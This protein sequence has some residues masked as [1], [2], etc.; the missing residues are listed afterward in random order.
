MVAYKPEWDKFDNNQMGHGT[1][2]AGIALY[3]DVKMLLESS[4]VHS[5]THT[6]E[7]SKI[8]PDEGENEPQLY[9]AITSKV[10]SEQI[11]NHPNRIRVNCMAV[12]SP[13]IDTYDS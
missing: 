12:T 10:I 4:D 3:D 9:G 11:I 5:V 1:L 8:L 7:S 13:E 2:M 6:L